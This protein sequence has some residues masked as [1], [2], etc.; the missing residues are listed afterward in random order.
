MLSFVSHP[1]L[2]AYY[3]SLGF[4]ARRYDGFRILSINGQDASQYLIDLAQVSSI[5]KGLSGGF[6]TLQPRYMRLMA[7]YSADT[8]AGE[9][10]FEVGRFG[11]RSFYPG[12]DSVSLVLQNKAGK[13]VSVTVP[14]SAH[15]LSTGNT[16]ASFIANSCALPVSAAGVATVTAV[17]SP[18][19]NVTTKMAFLDP[20]SQN[21]MRDI[22][23]VYAKA[24]KSSNYVK[25]NLQ[26]YGP[27]VP[28]ID[29][30][31]LKK[32]PKVSH[33]LY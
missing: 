19:R 29:I 18:E 7:R 10:A 3:Q 6:E 17:K 31:R 22:A 14:W 8:P 33:A 24:N 5:Y 16:T 28:T 20:D 30:Y 11:M 21:E 23:N 27:K 13:S 32:H 4:D 9:F 2:E 25:P 26:S 12:E 15:G 1:G